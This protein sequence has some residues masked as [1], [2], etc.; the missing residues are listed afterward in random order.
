VSRVVP[1]EATVP[2]GPAPPAWVVR[3]R[4]SY[5]RLARWRPFRH[6]L[7]PA[8]GLLL[9]VA[10][11]GAFVGW[12]WSTRYW[13]FQTATWDLGVY[14]QAIYTTLF[15]HRLFYYTADLPAGTNGNLFASHFS[16]FLGLLLPFYALAPN[17]SGLLVLQAVGLAAGAIPVYA[18]AR[19]HLGGGA[20][21][22][23]FAGVYL[24]SPLTIGTGWYDFHPEA[25]LPVTALTAIYFYEERRLWPFLGAWVLTL[26][27]IETIAPFLLVLSG[28]GLVSALLRRRTLEP[29]ERRSE[30]ILNLVALAA[31]AAWLG[32]AAV[33][34]FT[35]S[36]AGGTFGPGYANAWSILGARSIL[37]VYPTALLSPGSAAAALQHDS[38]LKLLYVVV[39]Y[40]GLGF[41]PL[42]GRVRYQLPALAWIGL[43]ALSNHVGYYV[44]NDQYLG[45]LIP[46]LFPAA[47]GGVAWWRSVRLRPFHTGLR[48][49]AVA[50]VLVAGLLLTSAVVSPFLAVPAG[51]FNAV[52]HGLPTVTTADDVAH[53]VI[54]MIPAGAPVF[55]TT[56]LFP[57]VSD[58]AD[59]YVLPMSSLF[60]NNGTFQGTVGQYVNESQYV[61]VDYLV[62]FTGA[63]V[64][65]ETANLTGFGLEAAADGA[66]LWERGWTGPPE[67]W[68]PFNES[69]A[70]GALDHDLGVVDTSNAGPFGPSLDHP[71][72][73][74]SGEFWL[75]P[76]IED[77]PP[78][79]YRVTAEAQVTA[80]NPGTQVSLALLD[81]G[82]GIVVKTLAVSPTSRDYA[83]TFT[84]APGPANVL[85]NLS[86]SW[87]GAGNSTFPVDWSYTL[88]WT[89]P[90]FFQTEGWVVS[91]SASER[92]YGVSVV[93]LT[94]G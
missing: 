11:F 70:G 59:A 47:I 42:F 84:P 50:G 77:L 45:Y 24:L 62:D 7:A 28:V 78:G 1:D 53:Q 93:Q 91:G 94:A 17:P 65:T 43:A 6:K 38:S 81:H 92:L 33:V 46:F 3:A 35:F 13:A 21:P 30:I 25:F 5:D 76:T 51:S 72:A 67:L 23:L 37:S 63:W 20:W 41:L 82:V 44:V 36:S 19:R 12:V 10:A 49:P 87:A 39:V 58:R 40:G 16:P 80:T 71:A 83:F 73:L 86:A 69:V 68:V 29:A 4:A 88:P 52:P 14:H 55:T 79:T 57:E 31:A 48:A 26:S 32:L 15:D 34:T 27:V 61:L 66:Y 85:V 64:L 54:E 9:A 89:G 2:G 74:G 18:L 90:G 56:F 22:A 8:V 60:I 75:G